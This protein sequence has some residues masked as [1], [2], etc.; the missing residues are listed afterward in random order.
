MLK[1]T[2]QQ[3]GITVINTY[4]PNNRPSKY[5]KQKSTELKGEIDSSTITFWYFNTP[6]S[7]MDRTTRQIN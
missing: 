3:E 1:G 7:I 4:V 2:L 5:R 6:L